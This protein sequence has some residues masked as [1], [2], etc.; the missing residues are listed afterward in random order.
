[1]LEAGDALIEAQ[2]R[3]STGWKQWLRENCFL[4]V[5]TAQ[6]Y[7]QFA[8]HR[9]LIEAALEEEPDLSLRA[10][11]RLINAAKS[12]SSPG[13]ESAGEEAVP[14]G[15][16]MA[17]DAVMPG[18]AV[19][20][21]S[22]TETSPAK[23]AGIDDVGAIGP[24]L[25]P[26]IWLASASLEERRRF[27]EAMTLVGFL[28]AMPPSWRKPLEDAVLGQAERRAKTSKQRSAIRKVRRAPMIEGEAVEIH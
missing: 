14:P 26:E 25:D 12:K 6:L 20:T 11:R 27:L 21:A 3:V 2:S 10:V 8:R 5:S 18:E 1:M 15:G 13:T 23:A 24:A 7:Q 22:V 9:A 19:T 17:A 4:A 28:A 16:T